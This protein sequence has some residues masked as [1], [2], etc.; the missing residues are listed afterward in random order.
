MGQFVWLVIV[1]V[2]SYSCLNAIN[3][4]FTVVESLRK[5]HQSRTDHL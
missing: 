1:A 5:I 3:I 2:T 4:I